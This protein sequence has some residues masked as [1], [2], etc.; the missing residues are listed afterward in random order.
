MLWESVTAFTQSAGAARLE[1]RVCSRESS[2]DGDGHIGRCI[3]VVLVCLRGVSKWCGC[4]SVCRR[5][6]YSIGVREK[7][8]C[9][10]IQMSSRVDGD[11]RKAVTRPGRKDAAGGGMVSN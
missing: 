8:L 1:G 9:G 11:C 10:D 6:R 2:H 5:R 3:A 7:K 4:C